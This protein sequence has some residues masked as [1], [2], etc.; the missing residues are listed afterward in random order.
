MADEL[1][2]TIRDNAKGP[3]KVTGDAGSVEQHPLPDQIEADK[4]LAAKEAVKKKRRGLRF[5]KLIPPGTS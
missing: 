5:N 2:D 1:D 3:A 4:H